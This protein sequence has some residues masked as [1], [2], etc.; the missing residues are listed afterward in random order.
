MSMHQQTPWTRSM[1]VWGVGCVTMEMIVLQSFFEGDGSDEE[2]QQAPSVF[3]VLGTPPP[4]ALH[5][6]CSFTTDALHQQR[7]WPKSS[8]SAQFRG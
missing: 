8:R 4:E 7:S 3:R 5:K 1:D 2:E 6:V